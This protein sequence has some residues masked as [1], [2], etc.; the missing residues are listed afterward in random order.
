[1]IARVNGFLCLSPRDV[2]LAR[3]DIDPARPDRGPQYLGPIQKPPAPRSP[4][5]ASL[6]SARRS[7]LK[8]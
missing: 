3:K 6:A 4:S 8:I 5:V 1:M 7:A 2:L